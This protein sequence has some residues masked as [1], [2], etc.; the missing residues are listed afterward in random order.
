MYNLFPVRFRQP[1]CYLQGNVNGLLN[2]LRTALN[3]SLES[4]ALV[5]SHNDKHLSVVCLVDLMNVAN[6]KKSDAK[7]ILLGE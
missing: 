1:L 3:F 2:W 7:R 4:F 5:V 6:V